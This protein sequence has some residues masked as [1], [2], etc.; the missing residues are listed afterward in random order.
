MFLRL[1][2]GLF[3]LSVSVSALASPE[4]EQLIAHYEHLLASYQLAK[5]LTLS[6]RTSNER[7]SA[8]IYGVIRQ[9]YQLLQQRMQ[10]PAVWCEFLTLHLNIK[11]CLVEQQ[12]NQ[13]RVIVFAGRKYYQA[14]ENSDRVNYLFKRKATA[15][16]MIT[17]ELSADSGPM[18]TSDYLI[19]LRATGLAKR[20]GEEKSS[21]IHVHSGYTSSTLSRWG[22]A[23]YLSTLGRN[24]VGF[25]LK[26]YDDKK[27]P[28]YVGGIKGIIERNAMRYYLALTSLF[29]NF[30]LPEV[31][32]QN[33]Q[34]EHWFDQTS[35]YHRQLYEMPK[36][37]YLHIKQREYANQR[38]MQKK[39][40]QGRSLSSLLS[41]DDEE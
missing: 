39:M 6:S 14:P 11:A 31:E 23:A 20:K 41:T 9:D 22:T 17:I 40:E 10:Q 19:R 33:K 34:I 16:D 30:S 1:L 13:T 7:L 35:L 38:S 37:E 3:C 25:S 36:E 8:D 4:R 29:A 28:I 32:R 5:S 15:N 24:K 18:G 26:G 12:K 2:S 27:Q 21:L